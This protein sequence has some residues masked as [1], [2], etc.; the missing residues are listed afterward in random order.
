MPSSRRVSGLATSRPN[1]SF[2]QPLI[3]EVR[4]RNADGKPLGR[5]EIPFTA[6]HWETYFV[7]DQVPYI[8]GWERQIDLSRNAVLYNP[9]LTADQLHEWTLLNAV[10]WVALPDAPLDRGGQPEAD[11]LNHV[12]GRT[13]PIDWLELVWQ[14]EDWRL[15]EVLDYQP[16]VDGPAAL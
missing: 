14:T 5:L 9:A 4:A 15:Y 8:R 2:H 1:R 12:G 6:N 16:I 11:V 13:G 10:R 7:A 3:D